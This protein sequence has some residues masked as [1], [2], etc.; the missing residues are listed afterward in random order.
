M[1]RAAHPVGLR[2]RLR[3]AHRADGLPAQG[4]PVAQ[5]W[6]SGVLPSQPARTLDASRSG[7]GGTSVSMT[8]GTR[9]RGRASTTSEA[10]SPLRAEGPGAVSGSAGPA[11]GLSGVGDDLG[12]DVV[13]LAVGVLGLARQV[14]GGLVERAA[15]AAELGERLLQLRR[16]L[17]LATGGARVGGGV[18]RR[19]PWSWSCGSLG[20]CTDVHEA[21]EGRSVM[22][23]RP[24]WAGQESPRLRARPQ[25]PCGLAEARP[26]ALAGH[27]R[28]ARPPRGAGRSPCTG[29]DG[30][31]L[32][33]RDRTDGDAVGPSPSRYRTAV[34]PMRGRHAQ[35][36]RLLALRARVA[37]CRPVRLSARLGEV[38]QVRRVAAGVVPYWA[39]WAAAKRPGWAKPQRAA[40]AA[41][42]SPVV[43]SPARRS[44]WARSRRTRRR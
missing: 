43:G 5:R 16:V 32:S 1:P 21:T 37:P 27:S 20:G 39:W 35:R 41:T 42:V 3:Q 14:G 29:T 9:V 44:W 34:P 12:G 22:R 10:P 38:A 7:G 31:F 18:V 26:S 11:E 40:I 30:P 28:T 23:D 17:A 36:W 8:A 19:A 24:R 25:R 2:S 6:R 13:E 15:Q 33:V 4:A